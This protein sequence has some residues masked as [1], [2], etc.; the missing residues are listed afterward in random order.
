[1]RTL[2]S[3]ELAQAQNRDSDYFVRF[4]VQN[5]SGTWID[6]GAA[7]GTHW[8]VNAT[9]GENRDTPVAQATFTLVRNIG[10]AS[11]APLM[12]ASVL[13]VLDDG[14]TYS[15]LLN[16]GRLMRASTA[17]MP[18]GVALDVTKYRPAV[19]GRI[20][21]VIV[22]D[23]PAGQASMIT[24]P[25]SDLGGW[26][27][28][29]QIETSGIEYG[30]PTTPPTLE[31]VLQAVITA[32]IP[33]GEP[34]VTLV[35]QSSSSFGVTGWKQG[36]TK[37][38]EGLITLVLDSTGEDIRYRFDASHVSQLMWFN[39]DRGR[40]TVDATFTANQYYMSSLDLALRDIRN[41]GSMAYIDSVTGTAGVVTATDTLSIA[42]YR[43]RFFRLP[44]SKMLATMAESQ[45][46]INAVVN[47]LSGPPAEAQAEIP[48]CWFVQL[49]DRYT[50][51]ARG[52]QYDQDQTF[53]V[54]G[55]QHTIESRRGSTVLTPL[56]S[57]IV[58]AY[59]AWQR[60]L[61]FVAAAPP[62]LSA[63]FDST[64]QLIINS[65]GVAGTASQKIAW[66]TGST[67][68]AATVRAATPIVQQNV[69]G[70]ATGS[71][72]APGTAVY[73]AAFAYNTYG[74][75]STPLAAV[76]V[77]RQGSATPLPSMITVTFDSVGQAILSLVGGEGTDH[78]LFAIRKDR[79]PTDA[80]IRA[81]TLQYGQ[82]VTGWA[83]GSPGQVAAGGSVYVGA[84]SYNLVGTESP[85]A[86]V[87]A[88]YQGTGPQAPAIT[89]T[90]DKDGQVIL[91]VIGNSATTS[92]I[93][94][95]RTDRSPTIAETRAGNSAG[96]PSFANTPS[97][98]FILAGHYIYVGALAYNAAGDESLLA[99]VAVLR[100]GGAWDGP[101][102]TGGATGQTTEEAQRG[103]SGGIPVPGG[104]IHA[105]PL[106]DSTGS[107]PLI[108][109]AGR[110]FQ[111]ALG[112]PTGIG[113][114]VIE[115]G[116]NKGDQAIDSGYIVVPAG[117]DFTRSY[118]GKSLAN[119]PD[120]GTSDRRAA[121]LN[122]K[123]GGDRGFGAIDSGTSV[124]AGAIDF[125]RSFVNKHLGNIPDDGTSDRR[126]AT[127]DQKTGG[128]RAKAAIDSGN[129]AVAAAVD[130][131]RLYTGK[132]LANVP[133]DGTSDRRASTLNQKTGGDRGFAAVDSGNVAITTAVD[134]SRAYTGK[135]LGN[136][137]DDGTSDRKA[138]TGNEKTGAGR[139]FPALD[140]SNKLI[141]GIT[142]AAKY[143]DG[144]TGI[145]G[146]KPGEAGANVTETRTALNTANVDS[147]SAAT[148]RQGAVR[149]NTGLDSS[150]KLQTGVTTGATYADGVTGIDG[151]KP[152]EAGADV[153]SGHTAAD[154]SNVNGTA[155]ATVQGGA[156]KANT[157]LDGSGKL[158][159]GVTSAATA[160]DG[161]IG[162]ESQRAATRKGAFGAGS[163]VGQT[164]EEN[165]R[166]GFG[167][168]PVPSAPYLALPYYDSS[169]SVPLLD[170]V[171]MRFMNGAIDP[172]VVLDNPTGI[173]GAGAQQNLAGT[174][175]SL[176]K[177]YQSGF[178]QDGVAVTF[179]PAYQNP[180][181]V[182]LHGGK[183][184][185]TTLGTASPQYEDFAATGLTASGFTTRAKLKNKGTIAART[186]DFASSTTA[187]TVGAVTGNAALASAPALDD[188]YKARFRVDVTCATLSG[189]GTTTVVVAI[190]VSADGST[191]W[192]EYATRAFSAS[193][194]TGGTTTNSYSG[195]EVAV[196]V[197]SLLGASGAAVRLKYKSKTQTGA[198]TGSATVTGYNNTGGGADAGH[199]VTYSTQTGGASQ[200]KT[201]AADDFV[202]WE[203]FEVVS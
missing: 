21:D 71:T 54:G 64:G 2:L 137:P 151:R 103:G 62:V 130:F 20:D 39:P 162:I 126:A 9:W 168:Y 161:N 174:A 154:T 102:Y 31:S 186:A 164:G 58:G 115:R 177:G 198:S 160:N 183:L 76:S 79:L 23:D 78:F 105:L 11:L 176:A 166:S 93:Y 6:V 202:V 46:V 199:G 56:T 82:T 140:S 111:T 47:D 165:T 138:V 159:T 57:R 123:T 34:A 150:G 19:T 51:E 192:T 74:M 170:P 84:F 38:L 88:K 42:D 95:L 146:L 169:G 190:E 35:K 196:N 127:L 119:V 182:L 65:S 108:D 30:N 12:S 116:G 125:V 4:E 113:G 24:L 90:F 110:R 99:S 43:R 87:T 109:T 73:I 26:L 157:G 100:Q 85:H 141:T 171:A 45:T 193:R 122:Q 25:C 97:G 142:A 135:H 128:D 118:T 92:L 156:A 27:M 117:V 136:I 147:V 139:A 152:A 145:D 55:Y 10:A 178:T 200:S 194:T 16:I 121:T 104:P 180:P 67:P 77:T 22:L 184:F 133:D 185:D 5:G 172:T 175:R 132:S 158:Q 70:W 181:Q 41:A 163:G 52:R 14:V 40:V 37:L 101:R 68:T 3:G 153:T 134:L 61:P 195:N 96:G 60:R 63:S 155:A 7:L 189:A 107:T 44:S 59:A 188:N 197:A 201:P 94:D 112:G 53:A 129:V 48:F 91:S 120:D 149:G 66:A 18:Y 143:A 50:F 80:E 17:T 81:G 106:Y 15:P 144:V 191:G 86:L 36:D 98:I 28:D 173:L 89:V 1:M 75:E 13:N 203:A 72:Y 187:T 29:L 8:I 33:V 49:Y 179:S 167:G 83:T 32:N 124:V 69:S 114:D 148:A 131:T